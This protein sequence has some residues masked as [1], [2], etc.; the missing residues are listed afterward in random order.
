[1]LNLKQYHALNLIKTNDGWSKF[2]TELPPEPIE[3]KKL[4]NI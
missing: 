3:L 4:R 2:I 1:L